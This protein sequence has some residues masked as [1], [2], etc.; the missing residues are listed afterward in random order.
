[1]KA[2]SA[3]LEAEYAGKVAAGTMARWLTVLGLSLKPF[4]NG[5]EK[6]STHNI[7]PVAVPFD[8]RNGMKA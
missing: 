4:G 6:L 3:A 2:F 7:I 5:N 8:L 1:M